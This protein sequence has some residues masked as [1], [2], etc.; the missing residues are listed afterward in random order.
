MA[1]FGAG[2]S[3]TLGR[4]NSSVTSSMLDKQNRPIVQTSTGTRYGAA[5]GGTIS[6]NVTGSG[7]P[8]KWGGTNPTCPRCNKTVYFAEQVLLSSA[9]CRASLGADVN[10]IGES[11]WENVS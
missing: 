10:I 11:C 2:S 5:L 6:T 9:L 7:S 1:R 8:K 4:S 3:V